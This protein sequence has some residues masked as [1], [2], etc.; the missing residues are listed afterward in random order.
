MAV[1]VQ[2]KPALLSFPAIQRYEFHL[3]SD[4]SPRTPISYGQSGSISI[5]NRR[6]KR[7]NTTKTLQ[8]VAFSK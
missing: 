3:D 6:K 8:L 5:F 4:E 1:L 7:R 2:V